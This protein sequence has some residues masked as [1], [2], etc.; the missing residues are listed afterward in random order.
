MENP[1][2]KNQNQEFWDWGLGFTGA[3]ALPSAS[4]PLSSP[5]LRSM[6]DHPRFYAW[7]LEKEMALVTYR[8][9]KLNPLL[10]SVPPKIWEIGL[11]DCLASDLGLSVQV[12]EFRLQGLGY[13][14]LGPGSGVQGVG[15]WGSGFVRV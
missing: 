13:R 14:V 5:A 6:V 9:G 2:I 7:Q 10:A 8:L 1:R 11:C 4:W 15:V 12:S 3:R